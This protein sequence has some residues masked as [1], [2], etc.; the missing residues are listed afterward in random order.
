[1]LPSVLI[2]VGALL[3]LMALAALGAPR[4]FVGRYRRTHALV[5]VA[6]A[7]GLGLLGVALPAR[8]V[9]V[10]RPNSRLDTIMPTYQ[11]RHRHSIEIAASPIVVDRAVRAVTA[12]E[13]PFYRT[14]TWI[15]RF[16]R[17]GPESLI[18]APRGVAL[19]ALATRSGFRLVADEPARELVLAAAG[20]VP[21][22]RP[23]TATPASP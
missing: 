2:Y 11:S 12:D 23:P 15:R 10:A 3:A 21:S 17:R 20:P 14:L 4:R 19:L 5:A 1:M 6:A 22:S 18:D 7:V 8:S 9:S 16:G 13:I